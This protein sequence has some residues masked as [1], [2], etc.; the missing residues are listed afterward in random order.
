MYHALFQITHIFNQYVASQSQSNILDFQFNQP[1]VARAYLSR[2]LWFQGFPDQAKRIA[3]NSVDDAHE[4][5][6]SLSLCHVLAQAV[7]PVALLCGDLETAKYAIET[8]L[9]HSTHHSL[10]FWQLR[11]RGLKSVLLILSGDVSAG[12]KLLRN[13]LNDH[14]ESKF[15]L[16]EA[17]YLGILALALC[18]QHQAKEGLV[19]IDKALT[20][21]HGDEERWCMPELIR[22]KGELLLLKDPLDTDNAESHFLEAIEVAKK[23]GTLCWELRA[24]VSFARLHH[25]QGDSSTGHS[26]LQSVYNR[27]TEGFE[28]S[29]IKAAKALLDIL[30]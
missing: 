17:M 12:I 9:T 1:I 4:F 6:H 18:S 21:S 3:Q 10:A 15:Y 22:I 24:A 28:T 20:L 19:V 27:F 29:D 11:G 30:A 2:I 23:Q 14:S 13:V 5:G 7:A 25:Q 8:L 16:C 26:L